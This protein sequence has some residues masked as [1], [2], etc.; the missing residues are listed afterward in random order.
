MTIRK[1]LLLAGALLA[2]AWLLT[3]GVKFEMIGIHAKQRFMGVV[4]GLILVIFANAAPK[5]LQPLAKMR[6]DPSQVQTLQR[7][8]GWTLVLAGL[9][10][11][12]AWLVAPI[13]HA[14][15]VSMSIVAAGLLL[16]LA[17]LL[18]AFMTRRRA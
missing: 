10:Y 6:C 16:V 1:S 12:V 9:G 14:S 8:C 2:V 7:F 13:Q 18:T 15:L 5:T 3:L 17:R 4:N 11:S